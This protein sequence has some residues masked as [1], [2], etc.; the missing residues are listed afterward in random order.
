MIRPTMLERSR[1]AVVVL[2]S[3]GLTIA[4]IGA[5]ADGHATAETVDLAGTWSIGADMPT[6]RTEITS[7][8]V[9]GTVFVAGGFP[10]SGSHTDLVEAYD[11]TAD[12]WSQVQPLPVE[13]DHA[14]AASAGGKMY[15]IGG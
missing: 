4:S 1:L 15:V 9:N 3:V 8:L 7:A 11:V 14:G 13:L 10:I 12:S 2:V 5:S 6:P